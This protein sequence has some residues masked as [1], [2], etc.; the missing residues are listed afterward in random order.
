MGL[1][2][3]DVDS[4]SFGVS[5]GAVQGPSEH[6]TAAAWQ[7]RLDRLGEGKLVVGD[8]ALVATLRRTH[9]N[10]A[11][12]FDVRVC[13]NHGFKFSFTVFMYCLGYHF[14]S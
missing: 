5:F 8:R 14:L 9:R 13:H 10:G 12:T 11:A 7:G 2:D 6:L 1:V 4:V 3:G